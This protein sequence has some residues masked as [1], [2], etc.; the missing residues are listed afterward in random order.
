M[1]S[2]DRHHL[3]VRVDLPKNLYKK[4]SVCWT[5]AVF[6][7][8]ADQADCLARR[9]LARRGY[10]SAPVPGDVVADEF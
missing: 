10:A 9:S 3:S 1:N 2:L 5:I 7:P 6:W 8:R 4:S